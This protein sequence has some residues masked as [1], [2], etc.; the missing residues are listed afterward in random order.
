MNNDQITLEQIARFR[1]K[2]DGDVHGHL[3]SNALKRNTLDEL[4]LSRDAQQ[5][6]PFTFT[7]E[8]ESDGVCN[9]MASERCWSFTY[10]NIARYNVKR[11][12]HI[13]ERNFQMSHAYVYFYDQLEKSNQFLNKI[14]RT[15]DRPV[16]DPL[17]SRFLSRPISDYGYFGF[18]P[19]AEKYGLVPK[20]AMPDSEIVKATMPMTRILSM[21][22]RRSAKEL[23]DAA[24]A[25]EDVQALKEQQLA[26]IYGILC[27]FLG[28]PPQTFDFEYRDTAGEYHCLRDQTPL[29]FMR[30]YCGLDWDNLIE[31][32]FLP[33]THME[34]NKMY[35]RT[36]FP[37]DGPQYDSRPCLNMRIEDIKK[38][39][40]EMLKNGQMVIFGSDPRMFASKKYGYMGQSL[41]DYE[42]LFGTKLMMDKPD[43]HDY[44]WTVGTHMML[45]TGVALDE[46]G[47]PLRWKVQNSYGPQMGIQGHYVMDDEWFDVF[48]DGAT[49]DK[50]FLPSE[51]L[52]CLDQK[53][54]PMPD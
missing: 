51:L 42:G 5:K 15:A 7:V 41:F 43:S 44:K 18:I 22:L 49:L 48:L 20:S 3:V 29:Q 19:L 23:R 27:R 4:A 52:A 1:E 2:W 54:E 50:R 9:Q 45:F 33:Y 32:D 8:Y 35:Y 31:V 39:A 26:D 21:K 53:P 24:A 14:I 11:A 37:E 47:K 12:L 25:G 38:V 36:D 28:Q 46:S 10:L 30:D 17:V 16:H 34:F 6:L 40:V 13:A